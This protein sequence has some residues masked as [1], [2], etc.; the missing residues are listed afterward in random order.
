VCRHKEEHDQLMFDI[1]CQR[2]T[3]QALKADV[4]AA[5]KALADKHSELRREA[6]LCYRGEK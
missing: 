4:K 2:L 3:I 1:E 5:E 6:A